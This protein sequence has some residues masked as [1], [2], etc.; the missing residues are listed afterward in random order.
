MELYYYN[1][2]TSHSY[3][4]STSDHVLPT[5]GKSYVVYRSTWCEGCLRLG[6]LFTNGDVL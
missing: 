5:V 1:V 6:T 4:S 3:H 2:S